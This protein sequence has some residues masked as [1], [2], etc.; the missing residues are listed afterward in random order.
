MKVLKD[1][2]DWI[3]DANYHYSNHTGSTDFRHGMEDSGRA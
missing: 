3:G 1:L 2:F